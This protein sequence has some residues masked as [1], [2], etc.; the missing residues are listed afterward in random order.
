MERNDLFFTSSPFFSS[1]Y[2]S[3]L[4]NVLF[5]LPFLFPLFFFFLL[6]TLSPLY[7]H[8]HDLIQSPIIKYHHIGSCVFNIWPLVSYKYL[9]H[10]HSLLLNSFPR[11]YM[12]LVENS[13][14]GTNNTKA[15]ATKPNYNFSFFFF[16]FLVVLV[17]K[18]KSLLTVSTIHRRWLSKN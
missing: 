4:P 18:T 1:F 2:S 9:I 12:L 5:F 8:F 6:L 11:N 16:L 14:F 17:I 7:P 10:K 15:N 3:S 13:G